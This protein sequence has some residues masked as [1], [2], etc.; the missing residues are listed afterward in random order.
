MVMQ[1]FSICLSKNSIRLE[2]WY[3][4]TYCSTTS[5]FFFLDGIKQ[6]LHYMSFQYSNSDTDG[7]NSYIPTYAINIL[8]YPAYYTMLRSSKWIKNMQKQHTHAFLIFSY[9]ITFN[10]NDGDCCAWRLMVHFLK[11]LSASW[12]LCNISFLFY[13]V[14]MTM[15]IGTS[16]FLPQGKPL[17]LRIQQLFLLYN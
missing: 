15:Y 1:Y 4:V 10:D 9:Y 8:N 14:H 16:L 12:Y 17:C 7:F 13:N 6:C 2:H 3:I 5:K 11:I